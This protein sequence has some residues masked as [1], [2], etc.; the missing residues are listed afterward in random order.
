MGS[1][2]G[3]AADAADAGTSCDHDQTVHNSPR[4]VDICVRGKV[5]DTAPKYGPVVVPYFLLGFFFTLTCVLSLNALAVTKAA[6]NG[7]AAPIA[8][9]FDE[10]RA[11]LIL[12]RCVSTGGEPAYD[13]MQRFSHCVRIN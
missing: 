3:P 13:T 1:S 12:M 9:A 2:D 5:M 10:D 4:G 7:H 6:A 11:T 8:L